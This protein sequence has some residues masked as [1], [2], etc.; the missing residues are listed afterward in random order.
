MRSR[1]PSLETTVLMIIATYV[2]YLGVRDD[3][4]LY[5]HPR[6][7][8]FTI[9]L[10][11]IGLVMTLVFAAVESRKKQRSL[12]H[13]GRNWLL[14]PLFVLVGSALLL[15]SKTLSSATV[16]Q[17]VTDAGSIVATTESGPVDTLFAGSSR[18][19]RL[20]DWSQILSANTDPGFYAT[21]PAKISGF[22]YDAGLGGD[23]VWLARFV[24]TCCAVDAQPVGVPVQLDDWRESYEE[25]QWVE[26]EGLFRLAETEKG[27]Q[28]VL[29]PNKIEAIDQPDNPYAN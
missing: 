26:V 13:H 20:R 10:A 9:S 4:D 21:K 1:L 29:I 3:L 19:L 8:L 23:T 11:S 17:R 6:Y 14:I 18:G 28:I 25:D 7:I 24:L 22:V 5:I 16:S 2:L 12:H 27:E 15:P